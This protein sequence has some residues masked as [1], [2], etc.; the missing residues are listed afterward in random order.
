MS[1]YLNFWYQTSGTWINIFTVL[2]GASLGL[3]LRGYLA[4]NIQTIITQGI[5]LLTV[6]IGLNMADS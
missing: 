5:G 4:P 3:L 6:W 2:I 1:L